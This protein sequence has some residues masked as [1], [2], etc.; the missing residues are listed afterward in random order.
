MK[1][2]NTFFN[3]LLLRKRSVVETVNDLL[4]NYFQAEHSRHRSV[5]GFMNNLLSALI[6]YTFYPHKPH[7]RGIDIQKELIVF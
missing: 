7:M 6:A 2:T 4:K 3:R 1:Q 5:A